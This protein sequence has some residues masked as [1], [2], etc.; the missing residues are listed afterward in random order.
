MSKNTVPLVVASSVVIVLF[1][2]ARATFRLAAVQWSLRYCNCTKQPNSSRTARRRIRQIWKFG[3]SKLTSVLPY[4]YRECRDGETGRRSGLKIR[5]PERAVGVQ[6]PLPAPDFKRPRPRENI[7]FSAAHRHPIPMRILVIGGNGFIGAP[8]MRQLQA[9][10]HEIAVFHR[11]ANPDAPSSGITY[12]RGD[13][14]HLPNHRA[15]LDRFSPEVIVD[16]ILSSGE[17]AKQLMETAAA[18]ARRV[19]V[20]SSMDVYRAWGVVQGIESGPLEPLPLTESSPLRTVRRLYPAE[21]IKSLQGIFSWL[22]DDYDK[23]AVEEAVMNDRRIPAT[24]LRLPMVY[25][26]GDPL[27]RFFHLLKRIADQRPFV[28]LPDDFAAWRGPRGYIDNVAHAI[29][30]AA[31]S[32]TAAGRIYNVCEEPTLSELEWQTRIAKTADWH[33]RFITLPR[34]R[35]PKHLLLPGNTAQHVIASS[36]RIRTE[37]RYNEP[38]ETKEAIHRTIEWEQQN[39][40]GTVNPQ[41]FDYP[42]E[43]AVLAT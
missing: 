39:P 4:S 20:I 9:G 3:P 41:Q 42:A 37:L 35:T 13:R 18:V 33:G 28:I 25:G 26:P 27:H 32:D 34:E 2:G 22:S 19:V 8:L 40:P 43:D 17:Q 15:D 7:S 12:I 30:L 6:V 16:L 14:N 29:A 38:F 11:T 5:R 1:I 24:V 10:G 31:T 36:H 23:I 21:H